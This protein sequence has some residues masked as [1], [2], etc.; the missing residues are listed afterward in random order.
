[1]C[2]IAAYLNLFLWSTQSSLIVFVFSGYQ[3][4]SFEIECVVH[5]YYILVIASEWKV[6]ACLFFSLLLVKYGE[7]V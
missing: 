6:C 4:F 1:M 5:I 2:L 7:N 3:G